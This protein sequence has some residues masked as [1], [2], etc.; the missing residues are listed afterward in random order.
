MYAKVPVWG[1]RRMVHSDDSLCPTGP[2]V[3]T[4]AQRAP[5][6]PGKIP[7]D[8]PRYRRGDRPPAAAHPASLGAEKNR[9]GLRGRA[10]GGQQQPR[11]GASDRTGPERDR[12]H[13]GPP[14]GIGGAKR[15]A[16]PAIPGADAQSSAD[17]SIP[18]VLPGGRRRNP[19]EGIDDRRRNGVGL[20]GAGVQ[21]DRGGLPRV[22]ARQVLRTFSPSSR[23]RTPR[24][25]TRGC[26]F[27]PRNSRR[28]S[29]R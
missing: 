16:Q 19:Q 25:A 23:S 28:R 18:G 4:R 10:S 29:D 22:E 15:F 3:G 1:C 11:G 26:R 21:P 13:P 7:G 14:E 9:N 17:A 27:H 6:G 12:P 5:R 24:P 8:L 2:G 20:P